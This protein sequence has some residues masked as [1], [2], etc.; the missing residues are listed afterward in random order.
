MTHGNRIR[1][2]IILAISI[3]TKCLVASFVE[4]LA[5]IAQA[6]QVRHEPSPSYLEACACADLD[7]LS[8]EPFLVLS[9]SP[10]SESPANDRKPQGRFRDATC[11]QV[12]ECLWSKRFIETKARLQATLSQLRTLERW[13]SEIQGGCG[14]ETGYDSFYFSYL[15]AHVE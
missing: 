9:C 13:H 14:P 6:Q 12:P 1:K 8:K 4:L 10:P 15:D 11:N 7:L 3:T 2:R 5:G